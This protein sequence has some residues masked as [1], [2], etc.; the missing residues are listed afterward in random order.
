MAFHR[1]PIELLQ[2]IAS[3]CSVPAVL[4]FSNTCRA[5]YLA[6]RD[7]ALCQRAFLN[8]LWLRWVPIT[9]HDGTISLPD[10]LRGTI[11]ITESEFEAM[12]RRAGA[13]IVLW[14]RYTAA[15]EQL[16]AACVARPQRSNFP[17]N[18]GSDAEVDVQTWN[19]TLATSVRFLPE[20]SAVGST[21]VYGPGAPKWTER[22]R[23]FFDRNPILALKLAIAVLNLSGSIHTTYWDQALSK[24]AF[25][26]V[27]SCM[28]QAPF[29]DSL[30]YPDFHGVLVRAQNT[31]TSDWNRNPEQCLG[32]EHHH[33]FLLGL[34]VHTLSLGII[35]V[36]CFEL[37]SLWATGS[38][39][40]PEASE[41]PVPFDDVS[42][43]EGEG[44]DGAW[45]R[46]LRRTNT[47][48][49]RKEEIEEIVWLGQLTLGP[50]ISSFDDFGYGPS[51]L[52]MQQARESHMACFPELLRGLRF[53]VQPQ[54]TVDGEWSLISGTGTREDR[55]LILA[56]HIRPTES[57]IT[58]TLDSPTMGRLL[59]EGR[60]SPYGMVGFWC[61]EGYLG[62]Q[63]FFWFFKEMY[64]CD[65]L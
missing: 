28:N 12:A 62:V 48:Y 41:L 25:F 15:L 16:R 21:Y 63:G 10:H 61:H 34:L 49:C 40:E 45:D 52:A 38:V 18:A 2:D 32:D 36:P 30:S 5:A 11:P 50:Y 31:L 55:E 65:W 47:R 39:S 13:D 7:A 27:W 26:F 59:L 46:W 17:Y 14:A 51:D 44:G 64:Y 43:K 29:N 4:A 35:E 54:E 6:C 20:L 58:L 33:Y 42:T 9:G 22:G 37:P 19:R 23:Y 3:R 1:L 53:T 24:L 8:Q 60:I 57:R 56:G